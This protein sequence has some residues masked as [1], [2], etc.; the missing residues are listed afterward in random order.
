MGQSSLGRGDALSTHP[1]GPKTL[2][3]SKLVLAS[4]LKRMVQEFLFVAK[5]VIISRKMKEK[6]A[7]FPMKI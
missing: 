7:I 4:T 3:D 2:I 1:D 5:V 6:V